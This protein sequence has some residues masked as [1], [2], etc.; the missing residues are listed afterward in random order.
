MIPSRASAIG[1]HL[2]FLR[3]FGRA[4]TGSQS[5]GDA[6]AGA[7]LVALL[8]DNSLLEPNLTLKVGLFRVMH[9]LKLPTPL[10]DANA[11]ERRLSQLTPLHRAALLLLTIEELSIAE[12]AQVFGQSQ[13]D[14]REL[15]RKARDEL[16]ECMAGRILIIEGEPLIA[17][18]LERSVTALGHH[19]T[20]VARTHAHAVMLGKQDRPDLILSD[21]QLADHSS[22]VAAVNELLKSIGDVPVIFIT[23]FPELLLNGEGCEPTY[24]I[25]KP[26]TADQIH[27]AVSQALFFGTT[28]GIEPV[29]EYAS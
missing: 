3:R 8:E 24:L 19:V 29:A 5:L 14:V 26:Y 25:P 18:D 20:G 27:S 10:R 4:M 21:I 2:P 9:S 1:K 22:G 28:E 6:Y 13:S 12:I 16:A 17:E 23:A 15:I 11:P 7:V